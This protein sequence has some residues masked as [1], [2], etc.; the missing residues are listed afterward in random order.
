MLRCWMVD[1]KPTKWSLFRDF[2]QFY[3]N[4]SHYPIIGISPYRALFGSESKMIV[5]GCDIPQSVIHSMQ[6]AE[7][8]DNTTQIQLPH[9]NETLNYPTN[10]EVPLHS[11]DSSQIEE[12]GNI[13][14]MRIENIESPPLIVQCVLF[15]VKKHHKHIFVVL[16]QAIVNER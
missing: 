1:N 12:L 5:K 14:V 16:E 7:D 10:I 15:A 2:V 9:G 11:D 4:S 13:R 8:S 6:A 3:K